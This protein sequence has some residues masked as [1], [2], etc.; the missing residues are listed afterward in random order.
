MHCGLDCILDLGWS[1]L[2]GLLFF[3]KKYNDREGKLTIANCG[4]TALI[5]SWSWPHS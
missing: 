1:E 4:E 3:L 5:L 2:F